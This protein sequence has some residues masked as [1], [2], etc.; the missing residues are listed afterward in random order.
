MTR[1][2]RILLSFSLVLI[3]S[4]AVVFVV[5][6]RRIGKLALGYLTNDLEQV[7]SRRR[8]TRNPMSRGQQA[9]TGP[10]ALRSKQRR[11]LDCWW[12]ADTEKCAHLKLL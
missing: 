7:T 3:A 2:T 9:H 10:R 5:T 8:A 4:G 6:P 1:R 12:T 11:Q